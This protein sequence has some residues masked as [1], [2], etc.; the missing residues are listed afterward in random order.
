MKMSTQGESKVKREERD[1]S[2]VCERSVWE[3][4]RI[5]SVNSTR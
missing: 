4:K 2:R 3:N 1:M 5:A